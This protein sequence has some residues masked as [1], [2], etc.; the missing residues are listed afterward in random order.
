MEHGAN[1]KI[2]K[3]MKQKGVSWQGRELSKGGI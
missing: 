1:G 2:E 3:E